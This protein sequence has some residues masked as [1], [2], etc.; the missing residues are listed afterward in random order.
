MFVCYNG[1]NAWNIKRILKALFAKFWC[2]LAKSVSSFTFIP[3][4]SVVQD[5]GLVTCG[6]PQVTQSFQYYRIFRLIFRSFCGI[7]R[8]ETGNI[9]KKSRKD[10]LRHFFRIFMAK[11]L[12]KQLK[13]FAV[14]NWGQAR[15]IP[16][17]L[18]KGLPITGT[19]GVAAASPAWYII[20]LWH[21]QQMKITTR[22]NTI[23]NTRHGMTM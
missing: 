7:F 18:T 16:R 8:G 14:N 3:G 11:P 21:L 1:W 10:V 22:E 19:R 4:I 13:P 20:C 2:F 23:P 17:K 15:K 6:S 9:F 5:G 12:W